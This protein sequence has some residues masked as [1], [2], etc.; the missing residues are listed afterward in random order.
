MK[1]VFALMMHYILCHIAVEPE[2]T[3]LLSIIVLA[4]DDLLPKMNFFETLIF[5][6]FC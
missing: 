3:L 2:K 4:D 1:P 6:W 5:L